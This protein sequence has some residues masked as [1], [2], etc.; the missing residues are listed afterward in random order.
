[1][2]IEELQISRHISNSVRKE[3]FTIVRVRWNL[4]DH[5]DGQN[6]IVRLAVKHRKR[7]IVDAFVIDHVMQLAWRLIEH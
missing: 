5:N 4:S 6:G 1:M 2:S 7:G 3:R